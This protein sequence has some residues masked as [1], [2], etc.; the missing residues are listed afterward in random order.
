MHAVVPLYICTGALFIDI[1]GWRSMLTWKR[2][3]D[4][5]IGVSNVVVNRCCSPRT[6]TNLSVWVCGS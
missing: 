4:Q 2:S 3:D 5:G 1:G 6:E